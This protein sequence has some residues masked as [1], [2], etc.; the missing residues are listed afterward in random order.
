MRMTQWPGTAVCGV[1]LAGL[2][3]APAEGVEWRSNQTFHSASLGRQA[4]YDLLLPDF[5]SPLA[6]YPVLYMLHERQQDYSVWRFHSNL[7][8]AMGGRQF[9]VVLPSGTNS[10][11][12][13]RYATFITR[14]LPDHIAATWPVS[15]LRGIAGIGAGGYGAFYVGGQVAALDARSFRTV[16]SMS[17]AF[18]DPSIALALD[19][20][21]INSRQQLAQSLTASAAMH[22]PLFFDCGNEDTFNNWGPT[23]YSLADSNDAMRDQ[24]V[25][26]GRIVGT[27]VFYFRPAGDH[28]WTYWNSR[29]PAHLAFHESLFATFPSIAITS[30]L[31]GAS[32]VYTTDVVRVA[33]LASVADGIA[34]VAWSSSSRTLVT[35][36]PAAGTDGWMADVPLG[37]GNN[38]ITITATSFGGTN[39]SAEVTLF[40]RSFSFRVRKISV[41][42]R[43]VVARTSDITFS[44]AVSLLSPPS[45]ARFFALDA[46]YQPLT[47]S[48]WQRKGAY[49]AKYRYKTTN[50]VVNAKVNGNPRKDT[51]VVSI[52]APRTST[53]T[54]FQ[55]YVRPSTVVALT[56]QL[57]TYHGETNLPLNA[58]GRFRYRG[59]WIIE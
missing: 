43:H 27:N 22:V 20:V 5:Y 9:I 50:I 28:T 48:F 33:G 18:V 21:S 23:N 46:L 12:M 40:R 7:A 3:A 11:Y 37:P 8:A 6:R 1:L 34:A 58:R 10:W 44:D 13:G 51:F 15:N 38:T 31:G 32:A 16:S 55:D 2:L 17:G 42:K 45:G 53:F 19:G 26:R 29:I 36:G 52:K 14:D 56:N 35:N 59:P 24:L 49:S 4:T 39:S 30:E 25:A 41:S 57:D 47:D 54:N